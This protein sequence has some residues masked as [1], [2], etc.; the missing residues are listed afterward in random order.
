MNRENYLEDIKTKQFKA[1]KSFPIDK[2]IWD[3]LAKG[4]EK[5]PQ[6]RLTILEYIKHPAFDAI[7]GKYKFLVEIS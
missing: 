5:D 1:D 2:E 3:L 7:R 4:Y 6:K